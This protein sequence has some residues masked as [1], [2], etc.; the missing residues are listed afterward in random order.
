MKPLTDLQINQ[1]FA[2]DP[3]YYGT[4]SKDELPT[5]NKFGDRYAIV[6]MENHNVGNGTHWVL[7]YNC[8]PKS[9]YY[10][11]SEG[12]VPPT[13]ILKFM[14]ATG[15]QMHNNPYRIQKLDTNTCGYYCVFMASG[16]RSGSTDFNA[17]L[18]RFSDNANDNEEFI[19]WVWK[20]RSLWLP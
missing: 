3:K 2:H 16:L 19:A 14:R 13:S 6:N 15:K 9:V 7:L 5:V 18:K 11:D 10:F 20:Q 8:D 12:Q 17:M 1:F 4:I